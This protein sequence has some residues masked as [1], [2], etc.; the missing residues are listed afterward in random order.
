MKFNPL[1][2]NRRQFLLRSAM[3]SG[4]IIATNLLSKSKIF[5]QAP[6]IITSDKLRPT[7]PYG[8]A[9]TAWRK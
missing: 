3:T 5:A 2:L 9:S 4:G 7:I 8:V 1:K 6:A